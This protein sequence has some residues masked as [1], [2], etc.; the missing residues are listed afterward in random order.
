[1]P[2]TC[3][4]RGYIYFNAHRKYGFQRLAY[5]AEGFEL[6][7]YPPNDRVGDTTIVVLRKPG[8]DANRLP[9]QSDDFARAHAAR[10]WPET[11]CA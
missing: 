1:M 10:T 8:A 4:P 9:L 7:G 2:A 5:I 6:V 11:T 3:A